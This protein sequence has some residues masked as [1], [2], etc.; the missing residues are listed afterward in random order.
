M[1]ELKDE[2]EEAR[3]LAMEWEARYKEMQRQIEDIEGA[4]PYGKKNSNA[5]FERPALQRGLS[6]AS[7]GEDW[8]RV[9]FIKGSF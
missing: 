5:G 7:E 6:T 4:A 2:V 1:E 3:K 9:V 8:Q